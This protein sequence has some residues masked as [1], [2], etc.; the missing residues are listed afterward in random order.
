VHRLLKIDHALENHHEEEM[1]VGEMISLYVIQVDL[2]MLVH[3]AHGSK[4]QAK[5][6]ET[7][8]VVAVAI[9]QETDFP[10]MTVVL[11]EE[12]VATMF[13]QQAIVL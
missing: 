12:M 4:I 3:L 7:D 2:E 6:E 10:E 9:D 1:P 8:L 5:I 11:K 13:V